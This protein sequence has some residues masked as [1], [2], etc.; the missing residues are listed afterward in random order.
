V[1][2]DFSRSDFYF[3][4]FCPFVTWRMFLSNVQLAIN[5]P[6]SN[7]FLSNLTIGHVIINEWIGTL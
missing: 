6:S 3:F 7:L 2:V 4:T 5:I 1:M